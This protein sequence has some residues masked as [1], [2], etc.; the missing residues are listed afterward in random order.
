MVPDLL[1]EFRQ[2][3]EL[4][5]VPEGQLQWLID[6]GRLETLA[7]G[8]RLFGPGDDIS[9]LRIILAGELVLYRSQAGARKF[10]ATMEKGEITGTLPYS[11]MKRVSMEGVVAGGGEL[12]SFVLDRSH[13]PEMISQHYDLTEAMV[14]VMTDRVRFFTQQ[15]QQD[16]KMLALGKLSAGLAH[17]LNNPSAAVMRTAQALKKHLGNEPERFKAVIKIQTTDVVV[18]QVNDLVVAKI[19]GNNHPPLSLSERTERE[20]EL[21]TWLEENEIDNVYEIAENYT[22]FTV[23]VDDLEKLKGA[24]R[25]ED[26]SAVLNWISQVLITERMVNEIQESS[27]RINALVSS[28]KAYTHMDQTPEKQRA[29]VHAGIQ[30]TLTMM[31]HKIKHSNVQVVL[32]FEADLPQANLLVSAF[33]QVWTNLIDNALDAMEGRTGNVLEIRTQR[34]REFIW[35]FIIDNGPGIPD[36]VKDRI[37]DPFFTTKTIGKGTGLGLEVVRQIVL[38]HDGKVDVTSAPGRTEFKVCFPIG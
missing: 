16:E 28:I 7:E 37:F 32:N 12:V 13:F 6:K 30:S 29:D 14:H 19:A 21:V 17:E 25:R 34:S 9:T 27:R 31:N 18:D 3:P 15:Q 22:V 5:A 20:D 33:N 38:Q 10:F 26:L 24:I 1:N 36:E 11:R 4:A 8:T 35:V 2:I 23:S